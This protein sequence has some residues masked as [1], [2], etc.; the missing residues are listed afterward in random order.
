MACVN[1]SPKGI[2]LIIWCLS[3]IVL[4]ITKL[5]IAYQNTRIVYVVLWLPK[6]CPELSLIERFWQHM[7]QV[8]FDNYYFGD[9]SNLEEAVHLFFK[10]HNTQ[11]PSDLT[12][13]FRLSKNLSED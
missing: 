11:P 2:R 5:L 12:I 13:D 1:Y 9:E 8:V 6:Y 7:K 4:A 10:E 3:L